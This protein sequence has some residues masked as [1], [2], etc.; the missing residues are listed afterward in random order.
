[1]PPVNLAWGCKV[2]ERLVLVSLEDI[3]GVG[4]H[5]PHCETVCS[6]PIDKLDRGL[7][8]SCTNC[9][10][11]LADATPS[12]SEQTDERIVGQLMQLLRIIRRRPFGKSLRFQIVQ[13]DEQR[14][15]Q[16]WPANCAEAL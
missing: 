4:W 7:P 16:G 8:R 11:E 1:M 9:K 2:S 12:E 6:I 3:I 14:D 13:D 15:R 5:C 10:E